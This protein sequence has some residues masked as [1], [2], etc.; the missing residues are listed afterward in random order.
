[1]GWSGACARL[2]VPASQA[3][4]SDTAARRVESD[5][6]ASRQAVNQVTVHGRAIDPTGLASQRTLVQGRWGPEVSCRRY[7]TYQLRQR[8]PRG[9]LNL[10][11]STGRKYVQPP[12]PGEAARL[13]APP[14]S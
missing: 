6:S 12:A 11:R 4:V 7:D 9:Q 14:T 1:M 3:A 10:E 2:P 8:Q 5:A 13:I